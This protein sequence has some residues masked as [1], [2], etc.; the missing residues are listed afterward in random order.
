M[1]LQGKKIDQV[2]DIPHNQELKKVVLTAMLAAAAVVAGYLLMA[3]PNIELITFILFL[4]GFKLG[5]YYGILA[6]LSAGIIYFGLNPQGG[7]FPPLLLGQLV[8]IILSPIAGALTYRFNLSG[9]L[10]VAILAVSALIVTFW[11]DL[12]TNLAFPLSAGFTYEATIAT[13][14]AGI[15]FSVIHIF[16]NMLIFTFLAAPA[17]K[18]LDRY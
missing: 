6:A 18:L 3:V 17:F 8:G 1:T 9:K 2:T 11:Y 12:L 5:V 4:A 10:R 15:P 13:L 16:G 14:I 7:L